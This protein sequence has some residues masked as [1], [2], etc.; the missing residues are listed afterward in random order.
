MTVINIWYNLNRQQHKSPDNTEQDSQIS[1]YIKITWQLHLVYSQK[2]VSKSKN[3]TGT[4]SQTLCKNW[5]F[6]V[7]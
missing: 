7:H 1:E 4:D 2:T 3:D 5:K 6:G